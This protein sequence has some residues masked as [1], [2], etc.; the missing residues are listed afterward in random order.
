MKPIRPAAMMT[1]G[2][3]TRNRNSAMNAEMAIAIITRFLSARVP[4]RITACS[5]TASTPALSPKNSPSIAVTSP[6]AA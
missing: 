1:M 3:G 5:T 4:M 2:N 6:K